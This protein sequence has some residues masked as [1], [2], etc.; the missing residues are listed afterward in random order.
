MLHPVS[1]IRPSIHLYNKTRH[2]HKHPS[3]HHSLLFLY[4]SLE[5]ISLVCR[6]TLGIYTL[7]SFLLSASLQSVPCYLVPSSSLPVRK[8]SLTTASTV[9]LY[10]CLYPYLYFCSLPAVRLTPSSPSYDDS[11]LYLWPCVSPHYIPTQLTLTRT[12]A[13]FSPTPT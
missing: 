4:P 11:A 1:C 3:P 5:K 10:L 6:L 7:S 8:E 13:L 9:N 2:H 12:S